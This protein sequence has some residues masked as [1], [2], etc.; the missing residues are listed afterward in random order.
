M[1][2][3]KIC[4]IYRYKL[5]RALDYS[6]FST[7]KKI[8]PFPEKRQKIR[9]DLYLFCR[10]VH[11]TNISS[12]NRCTESSSQGG[13][14]IAKRGKKETLLL[15]WLQNQIS[16]TSIVI[17]IILIYFW[18]KYRKICAIK[19]FYRVCAGSHWTACWP[20]M[21]ILTVNLYCLLYYWQV[22]M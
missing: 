7:K 3:F 9:N 21:C 8:T 4:T 20:A 16:W 15:L 17:H 2:N 22:I 6:F 13:L 10:I 19:S 1:K 12:V 14:W 5:K 18:S 11:Q